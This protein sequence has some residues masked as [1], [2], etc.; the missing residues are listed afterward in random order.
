MRYGLVGFLFTLAFIAVPQGS[1]N[2]GDFSVRTTT[3]QTRLMLE[4]RAQQFLNRATFG[5]TDQSITALAN[6]MQSKGINRACT[7]WVDAQFALPPSLHVPTI[8]QFMI[9]D[10]LSEELLQ[11]RTPPHKLV[12]L[13]GIDITFGGIMPSRPLIN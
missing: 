4:L 10:G 11:L 9:E 3:E 5:A 2:A 7:D 13:P 12:G 1:S 6:D 8:S